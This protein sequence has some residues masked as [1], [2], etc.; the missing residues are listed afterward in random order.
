MI[1]SKAP[2]TESGRISSSLRGKGMVVRLQDK[3]VYNDLDGGHIESEGT[4]RLLL[5]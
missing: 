2:R 3:Q 1:N 4:C 5:N